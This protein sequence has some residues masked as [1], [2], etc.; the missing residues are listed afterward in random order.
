MA[1]RPA[2]SPETR[3]LYERAVLG[4][5]AAGRLLAATA[6]A[7]AGAVVV[8][9]VD[10]MGQVNGRFGSEVGDRLLAGIEAALRGERRG[11]GGAT[12]LGGDQFLV[13]VTG[14]VRAGQVA[15]KVSR[16]VRR[17]RVG[18]ASARASSGVVTWRGIRP[19]AHALVSA[20]AESLAEAKRARRGTR[21]SG[22]WWGQT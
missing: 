18:R 2:P 4:M 9:D 15:R 16:T 21:L 22:R 11:R 6:A 7:S 19:P 10:G 5:R 13:V 14:P 3:L 17:V 1:E 20:A 12:S 8:L